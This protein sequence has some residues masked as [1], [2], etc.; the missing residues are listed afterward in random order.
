MAGLA[1]TLLVDQ[2]TKNQFASGG[3]HSLRGGTNYLTVALLLQVLG[4]IVTL[5]KTLRELITLR[6]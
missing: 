3:E 1:V 6:R 2:F 5:H 4:S